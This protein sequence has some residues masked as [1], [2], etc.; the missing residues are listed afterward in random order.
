MKFDT[1]LVCIYLAAIITANLTIIWFGPAVSIINAFLFI[2]LDLTLRDQLHD[3]WEGKY[4]WIKM[5]LLI[6][7]GSAIT[8]LLNWNALPIAIASA[9]AFLASGV[10][11]ALI[12]MKLID[13]KFIVRA[14]GSNIGGALV[15]SIVFPILAFGWPPMWF[16]ILGQFIAKVF[17]G[18]IWSFILMKLYNQYCEYCEQAPCI[19][20]KDNIQERISY[21]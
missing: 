21:E 19:C 11:D 10:I 16:I 3:E 7:S 4:L 15:D 18:F 8:I 20:D 1:K 13:K 12:Y 9:T 6:C 17:G 2:G 14:N 5:F